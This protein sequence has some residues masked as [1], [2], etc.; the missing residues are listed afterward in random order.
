MC[1][2]CMKPTRP[3]ASSLTKILQF[4]TLQIVCLSCARRRYARRHRST[5][6][7]LGALALSD[8]WRTETHGDLAGGMSTASLL[9][10]SNLQPAAR[11]RS[12]RE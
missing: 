8:L 4:A 6:S 10:P 1:F 11:R 7:S 5:S 2:F 9:L 3:Y 12:D